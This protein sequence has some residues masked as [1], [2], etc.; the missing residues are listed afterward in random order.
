MTSPATGARPTRSPS[1]RTRPDR[2]PRSPSPPT[3]APTT[4][5]AGTRAAR[6]QA[7]AGPPPTTRALAPSRCR[8]GA[9]DDAYWNGFGLPRPGDLRGGDRHDELELRARGERPHRWRQLRRPRQGHRRAREPLERGEQRLH[10]RHDAAERDRRAGRGSGRSDKRAADSLHR[11]VLGAGGLRRRGRLTGRHLRAG[12]GDRRRDRGSGQRLRHRGRRA[13]PT[14]HSRRRSRTARSRTPP[15]TATPSRRRRTTRSPTT[16][17]I[18]SRRRARRRSRTRA[19]RRSRSITRRP[20][21]SAAWTRSSC[22]RRRIPARGR[23]PIPTPRRATSGQFDYTPSP[24]DG[25]YRFYTIAVDNAGNREAVRP[26]RT[27]SRSWRTPRRARHRRT[28]S[29]ADRAAGVHE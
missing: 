17:P 13:S 14:A 20:T 28:R 6:H 24:G 22:G 26:R 5:R 1:S 19:R 15:A 23:W 3:A 8:S 21:T 11:R 16:T 7:S 9:S 29:V 4:P 27:R 18:R 2:R 25:T 12:W 10:L